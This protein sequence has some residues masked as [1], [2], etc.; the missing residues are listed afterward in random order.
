MPACLATARALRFRASQE[1]IARVQK[2]WSVFAL[3]TQA[4]RVHLRA[5][6]SG[7]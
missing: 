2:V 5:R 6:P 3:P 7:S 4:H 1:A